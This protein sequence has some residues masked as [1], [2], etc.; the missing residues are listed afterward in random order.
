MHDAPA[1]D[2]CAD[3]HRRVTRDDDPEG[4][5][6]TAAKV[7]LREQ[8]RGNNAHCLLGVIAAMAQ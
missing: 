4:D 6:K 8:Q 1:A 3:R 7:A 2:Q 5:V